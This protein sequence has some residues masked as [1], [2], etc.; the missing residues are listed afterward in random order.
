MIRSKF[1]LKAFVLSGLLLGLMAFA[2]AAQ[3]ETG[4][5]WS[6]TT[7]GGVLEA[8]KASLLPTVG[9]SLETEGIL[10]FTTKGGT[11]VDILCTE[12]ST[13]GITLLTEGKTTEG[14]VKFS[15]CITKLNGVTTANCEPV[16]G[17]EKGVVKTKKGLGLIIL[18]LLTPNGAVEPL[19]RIRPETGTV[20]ATIELGTKCAIGE[21]VPVAGELFIKD[22][23]GKFAVHQAI[24]LVEEGPLTSLTALGQ[25]AKLDGSAFIFLTGAHLNLAWAGLPSATKA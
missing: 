14:Q 25:P 3:A 23:E 1:G 4:A 6:L 8:I 22:C 17:A 20:L 10:L 15:K 16:T 12:A 13:E 21:E 2:S 19:F 9:G 24:H 5:K 7:A 11:K 18:H